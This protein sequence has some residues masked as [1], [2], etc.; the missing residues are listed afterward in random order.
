MFLRGSRG[1]STST[2]VCIHDF[3]HQS[4]VHCRCLE[5]PFGDEENRKKSGKVEPLMCISCEVVGPLVGRSGVGRMF[6]ADLWLGFPKIVIDLF[7]FILIALYS[8]D[9]GWDEEI[10]ELFLAHA[11]RNALPDVGIRGTGNCR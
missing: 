3:I 5:L 8:V 7:M 10:H 9:S 4:R 6:V 11:P 2:I 1:T